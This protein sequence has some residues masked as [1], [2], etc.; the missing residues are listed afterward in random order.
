MSDLNWTSRTT[1]T[2]NGAIVD[3]DIGF[4]YL[5]QSDISVYLGTVKQ[6]TGFSYLDADTIRFTVAPTNGT[7]I[8]FKRETDRTVI[9]QLQYG[10]TPSTTELNNILLRVQYIVQEAADAALEATISQNITGAY[11]FTGA[12]AVNLGDGTAATDGINLGQ[13]TAAV[14]TLN[15]TIST[16]QP[17][18]ATLTALAG[19][20]T[21]ANK[22]IYATGVDTFSTTDL[23]AF[24]RTFLDDADAATVRATL[25]LTIGTQIQAFDAELAALAGLTSAADALP[26][27]TGSGTAGTTTLTAFARTLL[28]DV[29]AA[30]ARTTLGVG[31]GTGDVTGPGSSTDRSLA[32]FNGATGKI[33]KN[34]PAIG[35]SGQVLTSGGP[36]V[37]PSFQTLTTTLPVIVLQ[38]QKASGS[39][40]GSSSAATWNTRVLNTKKT[41]TASICTLASNQFT[42]PSG[43]YAIWASAPAKN[44]NGHQLRVRNITDSTDAAWSSL[45]NTATA[46]AP[47]TLHLHDTITIASS[48]T[49]ELQHY[50]A[51]AV[52]TDGLG[53][54]VATGVTNVFGS[55][56]IIKVA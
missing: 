28:G 17:L 20:T 30:A 27:F 25:G 44:V 16:K 48:K 21:A 14:A 37:D 4:P 5:A 41:D 15:T 36:G 18:D 39:S 26:Y 55:V 9:D 53:L 42:L 54:A 23:S 35:T 38:D 3:Y 56:L 8:T 40:G 19:V 47:E 51:S 50:T 1:Y 31:S 32:L 29:D 45:G 43:T 22:L 2:G 12:K 52:A 6:T 24:A 49:F 46:I 34:G 7:Q 11:D 13:L 33:I 10:N